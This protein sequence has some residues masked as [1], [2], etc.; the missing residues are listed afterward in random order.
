LP[1]KCNLQRYNEGGSENG[2]EM[3][4][5][6]GI[7]ADVLAS[8]ADRLKSFMG[9]KSGHEGVDV[10]GQ[11]KTQSGGGG[12]GEEPVEGEGLLDAHKFLAELS[13]AL[14][15]VGAVQVERSWLTHS[16]KPPG[17]NP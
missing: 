17:F 12:V 10:K 6:E 8:M 3:G 16:L 2:N 14:G 15:M 11:E 7:D 9:E 1:F 5:H 13:A 4:G